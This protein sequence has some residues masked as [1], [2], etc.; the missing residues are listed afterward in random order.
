MTR[1]DIIQKCTRKIGRRLLVYC[2]QMNTL[3]GKLSREVDEKVYT[4]TT[5]FL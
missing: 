3:K 2:Y 4:I 5:P 1:K